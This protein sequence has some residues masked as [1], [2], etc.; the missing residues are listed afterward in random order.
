VTYF[1]Q[2]SQAGNAEVKSAKDE[3]RNRSR[4]TIQEVCCTARNL[5]NCK[6]ADLS[7][8]LLNFQHGSGLLIDSEFFMLTSPTI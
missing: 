2:L 6:F 4:K 3:N 5:P 7:K 8:G 1:Q